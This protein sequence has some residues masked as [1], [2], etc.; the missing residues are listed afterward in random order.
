MHRAERCAFVSELRKDFVES[1]IRDNDINVDEFIEK[2]LLRIYEFPNLF[3]SYE[4]PEKGLEDLV[5]HMDSESPSEKGLDFDRVVIKCLFTLN[6]SVQ[7]KKD[8]E[9]ERKH[10]ISFR[11]FRDC[12]LL[13]TFPVNDIE[14]TISGH[15]SVRSEWMNTL[16]KEYD[17]V[18]F[19]RQFNK[20]LALYLD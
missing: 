7:V 14:A 3:D 15:N 4:E 1:E 18:I 2:N 9:L 11:R 12:S 6:D 20:G 5:A 13:V 19:A 17:A 8:M 16:L 10:N